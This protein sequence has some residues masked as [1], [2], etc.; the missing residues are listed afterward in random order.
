MNKS[1]GLNSI[2][3]KIL[4]LLKK[5]ISKQLVSLFNLS[6]FRCL[7]IITQN[8]KGSTRSQKGFKARLLE[9]RMYKRV[10][11]KI[12]NT[13]CKLVLDKTFLLHMP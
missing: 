3:Y 9:K 8:C 2:P 4:N 5:D 12:E 10:H 13:A 11:Q 1:I 7:S 6:F